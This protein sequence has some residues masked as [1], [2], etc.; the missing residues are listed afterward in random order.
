[1]RKLLF[2]LSLIFTLVTAPMAGKQINAF[3]E[4]QYLKMDYATTDGFQVSWRNL[5]NKDIYTSFKIYLNGELV[6]P[7]PAPDASEY[8]FTNLAPSTAYEVRLEGNTGDTKQYEE[9]ISVSTSA[10]VQVKTINS[11][12]MYFP[13]PIIGTNGV[14]TINGFDSETLADG[15]KIFIMIADTEFNRAQLDLTSEQVENMRA[16]NTSLSISFLDARLVF[17]MNNLKDDSAATILLTKVTEDLTEAEIAISSI[18]DFSVKQGE[19][20]I[21]TFSTPVTV[22]FDD[23]EESKYNTKNLK[24]FY[25]NETTQKWENVGGIYTAWNDGSGKG[26]VATKTNH[27]STYTVMEAAEQTPV[28]NGAQTPPVVSNG[29]QS[30]SVETTGSTST[31]SQ[32]TKTASADTKAVQSGGAAKTS[33][34]YP[35]PNTATNS[36]NFILIGTVLVLAALLT[37]FIQ[38]DKMVINHKK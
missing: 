3:A 18:F 23:I 2:V 10:P 9:A 24:V 7:L 15:S 12:G 32:N 27:F 5:P 37:M 8:L 1:M 19:N 4:A 20:I 17:N 25:F 35:L 30:T 33:K 13:K 38:K 21:S 26:L 11:T 28:N 29:D 31:S 34:G 16:S 22:G 14:V 6:N 36:I